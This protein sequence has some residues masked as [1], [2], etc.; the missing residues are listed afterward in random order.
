MRGRLRKLAVALA[1]TALPLGCGTALPDSEFDAL[2]SGAAVVATDGAQPLAPGE[3]PV[4]P[5]AAP[6]ASGAAA[7]Q[8]GQPSGQATQGTQG[9]KGTAGRTVT[10]GGQ[11]GSAGQAAQTGCKGELNE[12][13]DHGITKDEIKVGIIYSGPGNPFAPNQFVVSYH[14]ANAYFGYI[15]AQGGICG[16]KI[17]LRKCDDS[18]DRNKNVACAR[19]LIDEDKVIALVGSN[20]FEYAGGS[21]VSSKKVPDIGGQPVSG[22]AYYTYPHLYSILGSFYENKG[23]PPKN[24][25]GFSGLGRW[26]KENLKLKRVGVI[27][28][29]QADSQ[30]GANYIIGWLK[31]AGIQVDAEQV[32]LAG[33]PG[34]QVQDMKNNGDQ[35]IFDALDL[36]GNQKVCRAM[37]NYNFKVPKISTIATWTQ[38]LGPAVANYSCVNNYY[39]WGQSS[40]YA[41]SADPQVALFQKAY[42]SFAPGAPLSQWSLEGWAAGM[43]FSDAAKSCGNNL[44]REC[45]EK[46][47]D[48]KAGYAGGGLLDKN[49]VSFKRWKSKPASGKQCYT[50]VKWAGGGS[51]T[52]K[53]QADQKNN[54]FTTPLFDYQGG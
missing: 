27:Y 26:F 38:D 7:P 21:Y 20:V 40:N 4:D 12:N 34:P 28:Y 45:I 41:D 49:T 54:C 14:G 17:T 44:S 36:G 15:N 43:W 19:R 46:F 42:A 47:V 18:G 1:I 22:D 8:G 31:N 24:Y 13:K 3:A 48:T 23:Q 10:Q 6:V 29:A 37:D 9:T 5:G 16:R 50:I 53:T 2:G 11:K 30:R 35:A 52:W 25:W 39:A 51:G 32:P 33:D